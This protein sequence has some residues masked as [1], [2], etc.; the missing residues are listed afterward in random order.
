M[1]QVLEVVARSCRRGDKE[2]D[3]FTIAATSH[4]SL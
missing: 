2:K 4:R 3:E 1:Y